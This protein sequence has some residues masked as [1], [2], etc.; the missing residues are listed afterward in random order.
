MPT[1]IQRRVA[2]AQCS[3]QL[4]TCKKDSF[5]AKLHQTVEAAVKAQHVHE[6]AA[7]A[8][9]QLFG[10]KK[11][12]LDGGRRQL[13]DV[14]AAAKAAKEEC[15]KNS[16]C[17]AVLECKAQHHHEEGGKGSGSGA[18]KP[19]TPEQTAALKAALAECTKNT[20]CNALL[21]CHAA[22]SKGR[23]HILPRYPWVHACMRG[24]RVFWADV[25]RAVS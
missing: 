3:K 9:Q 7:A 21:A 14:H 12:I 1:H 16:K 19:L 24:C 23:T 13:L 8:Q 17:K 25:C 15:Q 2:G 11:H 18:G 22:N 6:K 5:C 20:L 10:D 4:E